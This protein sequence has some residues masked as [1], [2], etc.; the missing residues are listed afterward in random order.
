[1]NLHDQIMNLPCKVPADFSISEHDP[2][3]YAY[4]AGHRDA[5]RAAADLI[6]QKPL[7]CAR[8]W[9]AGWTRFTAVRGENLTALIRD[10]RAYLRLE[11]ESQ[12]ISG[13]G[14]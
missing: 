1:M 12:N 2:A 10:Y 6:G 9:A 14:A 4:Q 7:I 3:R 13:E 8:W 5:R 11:R